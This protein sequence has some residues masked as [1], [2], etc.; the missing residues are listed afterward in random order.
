MDYF[1]GLFLAVAVCGAAKLAG[2]DRER[3]FYPTMLIVIATYYVLFAVMGGGARALL[4]E[5]LVAAAFLG[6]AV[7][8][9]R[10]NLWIVVVALIG[11]GIFDF[12]HHQILENDG[13]PPGWPA[14]CLVF[15]LVA[16]VFLGAVLV[17]RPDFALGRGAGK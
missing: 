8:G 4:L 16:A 2:F 17:G 6:A 12:A 7:V 14:F 5:S 11:H 10:S 1:I 15:D 9:F 3:V 13:V